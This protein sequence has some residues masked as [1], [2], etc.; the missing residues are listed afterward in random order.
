M[1]V[2]KRWAAILKILSQAAIS[3]PETLL[4]NKHCVINK[5]PKEM[6]GVLKTLILKTICQKLGTNAW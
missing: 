1:R 2:I 5:P 4:W 6:G 3:I